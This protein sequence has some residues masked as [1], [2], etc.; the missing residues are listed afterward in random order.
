MGLDSVHCGSGNPSYCSIFSRSDM[1]FT[2]LPQLARGPF[3][4]VFLELCLPLPLSVDHYSEE[5]LLVSCDSSY[6]V[7]VLT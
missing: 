3:S 7:L 5:Y 4:W 2:R 6:N 1:L